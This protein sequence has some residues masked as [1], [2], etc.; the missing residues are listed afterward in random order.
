MAPQNGSSERARQSKEIRRIRL[1]LGLSQVAAGL[2]TTQVLRIFIK[3]AAR[4]H[5]EK[6]GL[7]AAAVALNAMADAFFCEGRRGSDRLKRTHTRRI[8]CGWT[9][10]VLAR[11]LITKR[12]R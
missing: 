5:P 2:A 12:S 10:W 9:G 8:P 4:S 7:P 6:L 1:K 3:Y 11:N